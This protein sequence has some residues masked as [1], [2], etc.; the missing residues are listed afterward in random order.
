VRTVKIAYLLLLLALLAPATASAQ[1]PPPD[2]RAAAQAFADAAKRT[3][4]D[5]GRDVE[6]D[7]AFLRALTRECPDV[8][9][10]HR[11]GGALIELGAL[12]RETAPR[13]VPHLRK[14]RTVLAN[15][16]TADPALIAGRAA[17]RRWGRQLETLAPMDG[18][19]CSELRRW[20]RAGYPGATVRAA[21]AALV[22]FAPTDGTARRTA[23]AVLRMR[24][25]SAASYTAATRSAS[26]GHA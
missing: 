19:A 9:S 4:E 21:R 10:R 17:W 5:L 23:E 24:E 7:D 11:M 15:I 8:P 1:T 18:D 12:A 26:A 25:L 3:F 22:A 14:L 2:E 16:Q 6:S 13:V 20:R